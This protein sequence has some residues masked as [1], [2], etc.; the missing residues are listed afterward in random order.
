MIIDAYHVILAG[1][2]GTR[3]WPVS[4]RARPKQFLALAG[5][6]PLL[7]Q[8][9]DRA[10]AMS[11]PGRVFVSAGMAQRAQVSELLP[12]LPEERFIGEPLARNTGPCVA[13]SALRV[14]RLD[15]DAVLVMAP[16]DHV[17]L[18]EAALRQ[19]IQ[20]AVGAARSS[21]ALVTLGIR[22]LR[23]E[24]GFGYIEVAQPGEAGDPPPTGALRAA[25]FVEKPDE[26]TARGYVA[27]GRH[28]WNSGIFIWT[29][30]AILEAVAACAPDIWLPLE[31]IRGDLGTAG[32]PQALEEAFRKVPSISIDYAV[33]EKAPRVLLVPVDPGWSDVGSWDAVSQLHAGGPEGNAAGGEPG[34]AVFSEA[35]DCFVFRDG[36]PA[37]TA[38]VG[39][40]GIIVVVTHDAVLVC[41]KDRSQHVRDIVE[42]LRQRGRTDLL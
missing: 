29:A 24:T 41:R 18:D 28:Y 30:R 6:R 20:T 17:Y 14:S 27:T 33:L 32:E 31:G 21:G 3:F 38:V 37:T 23:P 15:P 25:R 1:G 9:F 4:R 5:G 42:A 40:E 10:A 39:L 13:L 12:E 22:P 26:E 35:K 7:R 19:A 8:A 11:G 36:G 16:A 2:S 34:E